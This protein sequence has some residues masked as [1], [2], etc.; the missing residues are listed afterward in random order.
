[1]TMPLSGSAH[2]L[3]G[4]TEERFGQSISDSDLGSY[5]DAIEPEMLQERRSPGW[6]CRER[7]H[8]IQAALLVLSL[9]IIFILVFGFFRNRGDWRSSCVEKQSIYCSSNYS[10]TMSLEMNASSLLIPF[11]QLL[12][13]MC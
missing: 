10:L 13:L 12:C 5:G 9:L 1:M 2:L 3:R 4:F 8:Q 7:L 6:S 11:H